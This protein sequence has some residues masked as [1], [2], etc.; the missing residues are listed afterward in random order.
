MQAQ[1]V[2]PVPAST[3]G[4]A[5]P[6]LAE[7]IRSELAPKTADIDLKGEYPETFMRKLGTL[8]GFAGAVSP[9]SRGQGKGVGQVIRVMEQVSAECMSTGFLVWCQTACAWYLENTHNEALKTRMLPRVA[10]GEV[11]AGTG[12]S[13]PMKSCA[14][15]EDIRLQGERVPGGYRV[16]GTLPWVSNIGH[17]H[18]FACGVGVPGE[19][20]LLVGLV[21]CDAPGMSI[22]QNAH[23]VAL[24]GSNTFA[25]RFRDVFI[26]D[27]DVIAHPSEFAGFVSRIKEGFILK[28]MGMG[29]GLIRACIDMIKQSN[30]TLAHVNRFLDDQADDLEAEFVTGRE[31]T[32]ALAERIFAQ[33]DGSH[34]REVLQLRITGG[35]LSL[36]AANAAMLHLG[37]KGYLLRNPAQRRLREAYFVAIVT[38]AIKHLKKELHDMGQTGVCC[39]A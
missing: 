15:I 23:F 20:G 1:A 9:A 4:E 19:A 35:E 7:L 18:Y 32:Y 33:R 17:G 27:A 11:L 31:L 12:L 37:A 14:A 39:A 2:I 16:N 25:C 29:L 34:L 13:N 8:G 21:S 6:G 3:S 38:P 10:S 5:L 22:N 36:K 30:K 26:P 28:Q 24:E